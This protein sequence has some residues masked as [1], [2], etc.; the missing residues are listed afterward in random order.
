MGGA[1]ES[2][3]TAHWAKKLNVESLLEFRDRF[4]LLLNYDQV[5]RPELFKPPNYSAAIPYL[6]GR[7]HHLGGFLPKRFS[8]TMNQPPSRPPVTVYAKSAIETT[9]KN[10]S[11]TM[12][13]V[14]II[15]GL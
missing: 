5:R 1:G 7:R 13:L 12:A 6:L 15:G 2:K 3:M 4:D 8:T 9:G 10:M 14:R 11:T